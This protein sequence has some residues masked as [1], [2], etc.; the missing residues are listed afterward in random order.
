MKPGCGFALLTKWLFTGPVSSVPSCVY[1]GSESTGDQPAGTQIPVGPCHAARPTECSDVRPLAPTAGMFASANS[2]DRGEFFIPLLSSSFLS[3]F[4]MGF[5]RQ[6]HELGAVPRPPG[7][8]GSA[9]LA[10][11]PVAL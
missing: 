8:S 1:R 11:V 7:P 9:A 3:H 6:S 10:D 2:W 5:K 4:P